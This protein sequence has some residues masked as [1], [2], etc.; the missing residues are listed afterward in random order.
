MIGTLLIISLYFANS[1]LEQIQKISVTLCFHLCVRHKAQGRTVDAVAHAIGGLR[2]AGEHMTKVR[3]SGTAS[4]LRAAHAVAQVLQFHHSRLFN[5]LCES[6]PAAAALV[7]IRGGKERLAGDEVHIDPL[8]KPVPELI[9]EG[10]LRAALL[11]DAVRFD[12]SRFLLSG[13]AGLT[14]TLRAPWAMQ[15]RAAGTI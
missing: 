12:T 1:F 11:G 14:P 8:F 4:D 2:I 9:A 15:W 13:E 6:R 3:I 7:L 5:G 10:T